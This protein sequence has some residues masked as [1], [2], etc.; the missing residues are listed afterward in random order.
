MKICF[1]GSGKS[2]HLKRFIKYFKENGHEVH[3]ISTD[4]CHMDDVIN[5]KIGFSNI[6]II[7]FIIKILQTRK[8]INNI[9]P[10]IV[11]A[12]YI[13]GYGTFAALSNF[14]PLILSAWG[15]DILKEPKQN[16][17]KKMMIKYSLERADLVI[18]WNENLV[19]EIKKMKVNIDN[20]IVAKDRKELDNCF[21]RDCK[22]GVEDFKK[23][24]N[25]NL[26]ST[27]ILSPRNIQ[28]I[29]RIDK[30]IESSEKIIK[31]NPNTTFIFLKGN[32]NK[33][34]F[35]QI[36]S[37][38]E[39]SK[40]KDNYLLI[41]RWLD[42]K[43]MAILFNISDIVVSIPKKDQFSECIEEAISCG[44]VP[45]IGDIQIYRQILEDKK[46]CLFVGGNNSDE[47]A[48][49]INY[50]LENKK[51]LDEI[52][53]NNLNVLEKIKETNGPEDLELFYNKLIKF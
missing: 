18:A 4:L 48:K 8:I 2:I 6:G 41:D 44:T 43:E 24:L 40:F 26:D 47:I 52:K 9:K 23:S 20:L 12:H 11:H 27:I 31:K 19:E 45:I 38:L 25:I 28:P 50:C 51:I 36:E 49:K 14:K 21:Q 30:I 35:Y 53:K 22:Q 15:D 33:K 34:Y 3:L 16:I 5:H 42:S 29:Y 7:N 37:L 17:F 1:V 39:N 10:D 13:F 46:N 32:E